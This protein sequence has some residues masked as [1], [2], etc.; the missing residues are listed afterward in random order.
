MPDKLKYKAAQ[1]LTE[2]MDAHYTLQS[3]GID[4]F[5]FLW[6]AFF[7]FLMENYLIMIECM[8]LLYLYMGM[9][10]CKS[11]NMYMTHL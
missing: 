5:R 8:I 3:E 2:N 10:Y 7:D 4:S 11:R 6:T 1:F 9:H